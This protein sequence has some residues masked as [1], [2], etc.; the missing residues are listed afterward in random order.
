MAITCATGHD[1]GETSLDNLVSLCRRH[2]RLVHEGGYTVRRLDDG[3]FAFTAPERRPIWLAPPLPRG[4]VVALRRDNAAAGVTV[5][6]ATC[7]PDWYGDRMSLAD[8]VTCMYQCAE[9]HRS[10]IDSP[11]S[12]SSGASESSTS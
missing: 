10:L 8:A 4:D 9:R 2:H 11:D 7:I 1:G 3:A 5:D 6:A 12:R